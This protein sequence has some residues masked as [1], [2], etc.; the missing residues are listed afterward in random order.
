[1]RGTP[2]TRE[3][4]EMRED[5][6]ENPRAAYQSPAEGPAGAAP[7]G[8]APAGERARGRARSAVRGEQDAARRG[9]RA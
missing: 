4:G 3:T 6:D 9:Y 1:M 2:G 5:D 8:R 7:G